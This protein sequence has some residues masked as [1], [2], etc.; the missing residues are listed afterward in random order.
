MT[1]NIQLF[2]DDNNLKTRNNG[3]GCKVIPGKLGHI[4]EYGPN[5]LGVMIM[6]DPPRRKY[7]GCV[8]SSLLK[9][10]LVVVQ[11]GDGEGAATFDPTDPVQAKAAIKAAGV[12]RKRQ[13]GSDHRVERLRTPEE[14]HLALQDA[15]IGR[16]D[17]L[18]SPF[19]SERL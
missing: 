17:P 6:P 12:R 11:N 14:R 2:A 8:R 18:P 1:L 5:R 15:S 16:V 13:V 19:S 7:W 9:A 4:Y 10:G 3:D